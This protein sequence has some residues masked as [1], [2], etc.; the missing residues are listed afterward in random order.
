MVN[1]LERLKEPTKARSYLL[2]VTLL[3]PE[4]VKL[5]KLYS[6]YSSTNDSEIFQSLLLD[7]WVQPEEID[8]GAQ[9]RERDPAGGI[10]D[11][12]CLERLV[13]D[14]REIDWQIQAPNTGEDEAVEHQTERKEYGNENRVEE[15]RA[16]VAHGAIIGRS[17]GP[18]QA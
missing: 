4:S 17:A 9:D 5:W 13:Q 2:A 8:R 10:E 11:N 12:H 14:L 15:G 7:R 1:L 3:E 6:N 16:R 18:R